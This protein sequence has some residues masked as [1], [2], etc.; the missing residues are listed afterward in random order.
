MLA[1]LL[2]AAALP[3]SRL[4]VVAPQAWCATLG[5]FAEGKRGLPW[6]AAC[7]VVTLETLC[8]GQP[9]DA[10]EQLKRGCSR[11]GARMR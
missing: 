8:A 6:M 4:I 10:V 2:F 3:P 1:S 7:E 5:E 9:G 11:D